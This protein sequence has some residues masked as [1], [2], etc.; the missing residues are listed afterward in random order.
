L[1]LHFEFCLS[2]NAQS[3]SHPFNIAW[4]K[5][6]GGSQSDDNDYLSTTIAA[7]PDGGYIFTGD[8]WSNDGNVNGNHGGQDAWV[9]KID[10]AGNIQWQRCIGGSGLDYGQHII[11]TIDGG[12]L[13]GGYTESNDGDISGNHGKGDV[14]LAKLKSAGN[15]QWVKTIGGNKYDDCGKF[16]QNPDGTYMFI[17]LTYSNDGDVSGNHGKGDTW[18][19]KLDVN[20]NILWQKCYGGSADDVGGAD[21]QTQIIRSREGGYFM[22]TEA[23]SDDGQVTGFHGKI[24]KDVGDAWFVKL[25]DNGNIQ[26]QKCFGGPAWDFIENTIQLNDGSYLSTGGTHGSGGDIPTINNPTGTADWW[27]IKV[28]QQGNL[29]WSRVYGGSGAE[30][31]HGKPFELANGDLIFPSGTRSND[32]D[33]IGIHGLADLPDL[34]IVK[35][36]ALGN[37]LSYNVW[38]GAGYDNLSSD[39]MNSDGTITLAT[40]RDSTSNDYSHDEHSDIVIMKIAP[41]PAD[42][43]AIT[44]TSLSQSSYCTGSSSFNLSV[45]YTKRGTFQGNNNFVAELSDA[46]GS[47][48]SPIVVGSV[49]SRNSGTIN[50]TLP[51]NLPAGN[52]YSIRIRSTNP[53]FTGITSGHLLS[54]QPCSITQRNNS[55][56]NQHEK[57]VERPAFN[58]YPNP[59]SNSTTILFSLSQPENLS[60]KVFDMSGRLVKTIS[61]RTFENGEQQLTLNT[62]DMKAGVYLLN[63]ESINYSE[64]K[65]LVV[66]K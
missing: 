63:M 44:T 36:D 37:I 57:I 66:I 30:A 4:Q 33:C 59:A 54:I 12:Y 8:T 22:I 3:F 56:E 43:F 58:I 29:I 15:I 13:V 53:V 39:V 41:N 50:C 14:Y 5:T 23:A 17:G 51:G 60:F 61:N 26:W 47:F 46:N 19:V 38:G 11:T 65:K 2:S 31:I 49:R 9:C 20:G 6:Y 16:I 42:T 21:H 32:H 27:V 18:L 1:L 7:T 45:S 64:T 48:A 40:M 10:A 34:W 52:Y 28:S 24:G 35:A 25:D 62:A 55:F